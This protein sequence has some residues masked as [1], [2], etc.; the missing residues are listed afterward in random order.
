MTDD[1]RAQAAGIARRH[2]VGKEHPDVSPLTGARNLQ[3]R[4]HTKLCARLHEC[5]CIIPPFGLVKVDSQEVAAVVL[6][7]GIHPDRVI[8]GQVLVDHGVRQ[9]DEH[10][11][12]AIA[13]F[14][15]W[16]LAHAG[17]P[18]IRAG[19]RVAR[20]AGGLAFPSNGEH[21]GAAAE[22]APEER[23]LFVGGQSR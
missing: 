23:D 7:Q 15:A 20:L 13:A 10:A 11:I 8:A 14:D 16:L 5:L 17:A 3:R 6:Q 22:Q 9:R 2:P 18:L 19:W 4:R 1:G 12:G 21:V